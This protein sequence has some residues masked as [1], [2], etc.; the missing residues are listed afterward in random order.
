MKRYQKFAISF[1]PTFE[2]DIN[3]PIS[4]REISKYSKKLVYFSDRRVII[5]EAILCQLHLLL[6]VVA[7]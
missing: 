3:N 4:I 6:Y 2:L 7:Y 5:S 1:H